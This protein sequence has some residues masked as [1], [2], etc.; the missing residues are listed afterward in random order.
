MNERRIFERL[1]ELCQVRSSPSALTNALEGL[2]RAAGFDCYAYFRAHPND[3]RVFSNYPEEWQRVYLARSYMTLDPVVTTAKRSTQVFWWSVDEMRSRVSPELRRF[4]TEA[5]DF[6]I[7]SGLSVSVSAGFGRF[8]ILTFASSKL[9][10]PENCLRG[11]TSALGITAAAALHTKI[12]E[13]GRPSNAVSALGLSGIE[14][15][16]MRWSAEGKTMREIA[17]ILGMTYSGVRHHVD[18]AKLKLGVV[19]IK[20]ATAAATRRRLI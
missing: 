7:K 12:V 9:G 17:D 11:E 10:R 3:C 2:A 19:N 5:A 1:I 8:A 18:G 6:N 14:L 15:A 4:Y 13:V 20:Q 16:C